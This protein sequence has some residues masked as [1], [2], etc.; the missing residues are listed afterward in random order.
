MS[1]PEVA[2]VGPTG[3]KFLKKVPGD[4]VVAQS[5]TPLPIIKIAQK[6]VTRDPFRNVFA[7]TLDLQYARGSL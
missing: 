5:C 1:D 7:T 3:L 2:R 4:M 6:L